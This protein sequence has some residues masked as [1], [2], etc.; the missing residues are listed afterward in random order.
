MKK[1]ILGITLIAALF[2]TSLKAEEVDLN[3]W[4]WTGTGW[5]TTDSG[6][7]DDPIPPTPPPKG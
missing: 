3:G 5:V 7:G 6:N 1:L 2:A 4:V